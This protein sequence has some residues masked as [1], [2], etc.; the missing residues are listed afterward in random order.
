MEGTVLAVIEMSFGQVCRKLLKRNTRFDAIK[1][2][3][4]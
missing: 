3:I 1:H 4:F 2:L